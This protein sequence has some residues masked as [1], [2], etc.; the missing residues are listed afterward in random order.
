MDI[1]NLKQSH[2]ILINY[3]QKNGYSKDYIDEIMTGIK[4]VLSE[5]NS[6]NIKSYE[7]Y[8]EFIQSK[9][10]SK[11]TLHHKYKI[12]GKI[13]LFDLYGIL[14][15]CNRRTGF[16]KLDKYLSLSPEFKQ[17]TDSFSVSA[18]LRNLSDSYLNN[19]KGTAIRFFYYQQVLNHNSLSDITEESTLSYFNVNGRIVRGYHVMNKVKAV[20]KENSLSSL[21]QY[22]ISYLPTLKNKHKVYPFLEED[23]LD[24]LRNLL[25]QESSILSLRDKAVLTIAMYTGLR[26]CDIRALALDNIDWKKN[27]IHIVQ[28]KT[29]N[30]ITLP[31]RPVVGN[32]IWDYIEQERPK[33]D[34]TT[35]FITTYKIKKGLTSSAISQVVLAA[36]KKLKIRENGGKVGLHLFRHNMATQL[37]TNGVQAPVIT[38]ILGHESP[39]SLE[40]YLAADLVRLKECAIS[41]DGYPVRKGVFE[42]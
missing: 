30:P 4:Q 34:C 3:L 28:S 10:S 12:I 22:I 33:T 25:T 31:L 11:A 1:S 32:A 7:E 41:I 19:T 23:E 29:N 38:E 36:F 24:K 21:C 18:K 37:L 8:Y 6:T 17:V 5:A 16:L 27:L 14:P 42:I 15:T 13:K 35:I 39:V 40:V 2:P 26:G 20:L 9:F